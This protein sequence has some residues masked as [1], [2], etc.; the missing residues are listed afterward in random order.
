[1]RE[2]LPSRDVLHEHVDVLGILGEP[3][4]I[5][6]EGVPNRTQYLILVVDV[7]DLLR[8]DQLYFFHYFGTAVL[9]AIFFLSQSHR[10]ERSCD[11][12]GGT[13]SE[14]GEEVV[15]FEGERWASGLLGFLLHGDCSNCI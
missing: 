10:P 14:D 13:F 1:M 3:L 11:D 6:D 12:C 5:H 8:L 15:F 9:A 2:E 4:E 7:V